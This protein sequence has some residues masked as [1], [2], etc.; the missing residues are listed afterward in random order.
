ME[1]FELGETIGDAPEGSVYLGCYS[2][3]KER[4][5]VKELST[6]AMTIQVLL[7]VPPR[8]NNFGGYIPFR[9]SLWG[10]SRT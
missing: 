8:G 7:R 9:G 2:D 10:R 4:V 6:D 1:V 5:M 3:G